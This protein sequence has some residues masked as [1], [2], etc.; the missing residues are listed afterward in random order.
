M[1][2]F[3]YAIL[4]QHRLRWLGH[5]HCMPDGRI[6]KVLRY[7]ELASSKR[8]IASSFQGRLQKGDMRVMDMNITIAHAGDAIS[9]E[10]W[11]EERRNKGR[12]VPHEKKTTRC[13][14]RRASLHAF[15]AIDTVTQIWDCT[16]ITHAAPQ[17]SAAE[18]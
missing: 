16:A 2:V 12:S 5:I 13:H 15:I 4:Q 9:T 11:S 14:R 1:L 10:G 17:P 3:L 6:L 7:G 8:E 18:A